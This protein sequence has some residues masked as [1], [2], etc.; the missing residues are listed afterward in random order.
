[1]NYSSSAKDFSG[2]WRHNGKR[3]TARQCPT[4]DERDKSRL[5][6]AL[7]KAGDAVE[8][9]TDG[10]TIEDVIASLEELVQKK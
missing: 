9:V 10:M 1:M 3:H 6:G 5:V 4:R 7:K 2:G 8:V